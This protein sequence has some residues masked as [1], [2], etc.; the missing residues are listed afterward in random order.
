MLCQGGNVGEGL[1]R[2][3]LVPAFE[4]SDLLELA[5]SLDAPFHQLL[6]QPDAVDLGFA[7]SALRA[8]KRGDF[9]TV[10]KLAQAAVDRW[11]HADEDV[12]AR[13]DMQKLLERL[14]TKASDLH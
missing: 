7:R 1:M 11:Q 3:V 5:E 6:E 12:P 4:R 10:C 13:R 14:A 8:E 9:A 2:N